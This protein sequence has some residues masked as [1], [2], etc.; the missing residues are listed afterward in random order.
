MVH[1]MLKFVASCLVGLAV[2][3]SSEALFAS[4]AAPGWGIIWMLASLTVLGLSIPLQERL[5]AAAGLLAIFAFLARLVFEVFESAN[6][7]FALIVLGVLVIAAGVI[8]QRLIENVIP[9]KNAG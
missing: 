5:F 2:G 4:N 3:L 1:R 9:R 7:A 6:A 8:Y